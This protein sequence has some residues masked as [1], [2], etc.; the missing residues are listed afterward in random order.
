MAS[1]FLSTFEELR[2]RLEAG[3]LS[4]EWVE[5]P[6]GVWQL[7]CPDGVG[8]NWSQ[9]KGTLWCDGPATAKAAQGSEC[10]Q[11]KG[12]NDSRAEYGRSN[13]LSALPPTLIA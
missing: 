12:L 11:L 1:K 4:G 10:G 6:N 7:K 5:R 2:G 8:V 13:Q 9:T 3:G